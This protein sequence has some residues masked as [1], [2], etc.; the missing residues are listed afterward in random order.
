MASTVI[1][2]VGRENEN[3]KDIIRATVIAAYSISTLLTGLAFFTLGFCRLGSLIGFF[4]RHILIGC[5]GG[6]GYFLVT[7]GIEVSAR[8]DG[9][10][11]Y[12]AAT[13]HKLIEPDTLPLW[14]IP[15]ALAILLFAIKL[16]ITHPLTDATYFLS[17]IA[18]FWFF[19]AAIP[20][21]KVPELR[22]KG[23]VF[24]APEAGVSWYHFYKLYSFEIMD[25]K[26]LGATVP[27]MLALTF[28]ALLH[29]PI[30]IPALS[31]ATQQDDL[32]LDRELRAH[33][34]S[35]FLSGLCG[36]IQVSRDLGLAMRLTMR[37]MY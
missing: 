22:E 35:N 9:N 15:L 2:H 5:I 18:I 28:F 10:L 29:V 27:A 7:T 14:L 20:E 4:P 13:L 6:V 31:M 1:N 19:I 17:I 25:W 3:S 36:S 33:G 8:L 34:M 11:T 23:W 37:H 16:R 32:D 26:A 21:L 24:E 30:N 12:T